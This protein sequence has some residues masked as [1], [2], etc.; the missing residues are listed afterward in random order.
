MPKKFFK[1]FLPEHHTIRE[2]KYLR[3]FGTLLH[4]PHLW[5]LNRRSVAGAFSVGLF[6]AF[7]PVPMQ[8]VLAAAIAILLHVNL[9]IAVTLVWI[10]N[11]VTLPA[12]FFFAYMVGA[13]LLGMP[14]KPIK[15]EL[16]FD[17]L[18]TS[19]GAVWEPFL[20]GCFVLACICAVLGNIMMRLF[21]R[22]QVIRNWQ[23]RHDR[24]AK[25]QAKQDLE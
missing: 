17:W 22:L 2:H 5:H 12:L 6:V 18:M 13:T 14:V 25:R 9:P 11:P 21:W 3:F 20:L 24:R 10:T 15:I 1:R 8:M 7:V 4:H 19:L 16:S 23:A